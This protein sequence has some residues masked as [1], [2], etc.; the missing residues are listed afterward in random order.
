LLT[1]RAWPLASL[2]SGFEANSGGWGWRI[3]LGLLLQEQA[4]LLCLDLIPV[5]DLLLVSGV[6]S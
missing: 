6:V 2:G 5:P 1:G 4:A 3:N